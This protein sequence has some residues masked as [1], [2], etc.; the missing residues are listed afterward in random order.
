ML[1]RPPLSFRFK[2]GREG[3]G[4]VVPSKLPVSFD[5]PGGGGGGPANLK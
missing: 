5:M 1:K 4:L 2:G 3:Q